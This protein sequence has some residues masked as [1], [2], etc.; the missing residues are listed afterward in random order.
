MSTPSMKITKHLRK[1]VNEKIHAF[2]ISDQT[3]LV[4]TSFFVG[5][6][7]GLAYIALRK[8]VDTVHE[9]IVV[10]GDQLIGLIHHHWAF[11][12]VP[13]IPM[14]G[15]LLLIPLLKLFPN[16]IGGYGFPNF[17]EEVNIRGGIIKLRAILL[18]MLGPALTIGS[19]GSAGLEGPIAQIGGAIGSN[20]GQF[21]KVSG[22]RMKILIA[23]GT[24]GGIAATFNAP[25][26]G[27]FFALEIVL[28]GDFTLT[29]FAPIVISS[30]IATVISR[31]YFGANPIFQV[32][33][34][35]VVSNWE[36]FLYVVMG[37]QIGISAVIYI[38]MF[39]KTADFFESLRIH[40]LVKPIIGA[41]FVGAIGIFYPQIMGHGYETIN[42]ALRGEIFY[43]LMI[44]LVLLKMIATSLTLGSGGAGGMFGPALYIGVMI[45][46]GYGG[47]VHHFFPAHTAPVGAYAL[48]GMGA[49]LAAVT[50][51]PLTA[52]FLLFELTQDYRIILPVMFASVIGTLIA[53]ALKH[54]SIDTEA[55]SRRGINLH[56]GREVN[57]LQSVRVEEVMSRKVTKIPEHM[58]FDMIL[59]VAT[60]SDILYFPVVDGDG[61]MTGILSFQDLKESLFEEDL[62]KFIVARDLAYPN[63]TTV[64][65]EDHLDFV[66]EQF[67][68]MDL[69]VLPVV[70]YDNRRKILGMISRRDV[71]TAYNQA[72]LKRKI[73]HGG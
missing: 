41:F 59:K 6:V 57:T 18:K 22:N 53:R 30:G 20:T 61:L 23:C 58:P 62:K 5:V 13:L 8:T 54:D 7:S 66:M 31:G 55:L 33:E 16:E 43:G 38:F 47:I 72:L 48:V 67:G 2:R 29:N 19:G 26:A 71:V 9:I 3:F 36:L 42:K 70:D 10:R 49:F 37:V 51:A 40:P 50:H 39:Y 34:Y 21:F 11:L 32:R 60:T 28:L 4:L 15:A 52:I 69:E 25:I 65:P 35:S 27:V 68:R 44:L 17:L 12:L 45:G 46:G 64:T 63:V 1:V 73:S 24:A 14:A 56:A